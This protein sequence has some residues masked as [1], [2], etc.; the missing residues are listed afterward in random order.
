MLKYMKGVT[1]VALLYLYYRV[2]VKIATLQ[3]G[4]LKDKPGYLYDQTSPTKWLDLVFKSDLSAEHKL[5]AAVIARTAMYHR[6]SKQAL[7]SVTL[8]NMSRILKMNQAEVS[9]L[10]DTLID[11]GWLFDTEPPT[12][13][14][15]VYALTYSVIPLELRK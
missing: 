9:K 8:Y 3:D 1:E 11:N 10:V 15:K 14:T 2:S 12:G 5:V 6:K 4:N 13:A 7:S